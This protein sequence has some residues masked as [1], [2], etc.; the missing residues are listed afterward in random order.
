MDWCED[1]RHEVYKEKE[2]RLTDEDNEYLRVPDQDLFTLLTVCKNRNEE[3]Y[4]CEPL[5]GNNFHWETQV[6]GSVYFQ[7]FCKTIDPIR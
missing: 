1:H 2:G 7:F 6:F 3:A 5:N 4:R